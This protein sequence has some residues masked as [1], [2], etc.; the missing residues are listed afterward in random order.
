MKYLLRFS[1]G[2]LVALLLT[3]NSFAQGFEGVVKMEISSPK[4]GD[5][6]MTLTTYCKGDKTMTEMNMPQGNMKMYMDQKTHKST[7]VME[8]M[9]MGM[10]M[11]TSEAQTIVKNQ[12]DSSSSPVKV[13]G[14]AERKVISGHNCEL[15]HVTMTNGDQSNWWMTKEVPKSVL[16]SLKNIYNNGAAGMKKQG[17]GNEAIETMFRKGM[18]PIQ[19]EMIKDGKPETTITFVQYEQKDIEDSMFKIADDIKIQ[20]MPAGLGGMGGGH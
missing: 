16:A 7:M 3:T 4:M 9:K 11:N 14:T 12:K 17:P 20:Q 18:A 1:F 5:S 6:K 19:I 2:A 10:E 8:A 15:Y 13:E